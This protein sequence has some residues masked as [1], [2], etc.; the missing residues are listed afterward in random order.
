MRDFSELDIESML[1]NLG[2]S[3]PDFR[4]DLVL[5]IQIK[6]NTEH[7]EGNEANYKLARR[8]IDY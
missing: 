6:L 1:S 3:P 4:D 2:S 7:C 8:F 5:A